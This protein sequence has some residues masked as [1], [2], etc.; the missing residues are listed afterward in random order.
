MSSETAVMLQGCDDV[1]LYLFEYSNI[2]L[3]CY[4]EYTKKFKYHSNVMNR[5]PLLHG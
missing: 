1:M 5:S 2:H 3:I 4:S